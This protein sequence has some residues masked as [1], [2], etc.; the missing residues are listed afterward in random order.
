M[1]HSAQ[2]G[3]SSL[4]D[5]QHKAAKQSD[6][7][8]QDPFPD[9]AT[10]VR[11]LWDMRERLRAEARTAT[12]GTDG[13]AL[14]SVWTGWKRV[15]ELQKLQRELRRQG[16]LKKIHM[17]EQAV[18]SDN[19]Y[20]AARRFAPKTQ[21]KRLQLRTPAGH[22]QTIEEEFHD[23]KEYFSQLYGG[24]EPLMQDHLH[25]PAFIEVE[26]VKQALGQPLLARR[27]PHLLPQRL[28]GRP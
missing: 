2:A 5:S 6:A 8:P 22:L 25:Q 4:Q 20:R 9:T 19:I 12:S 21:R 10:M 1:V 24:P 17:V 3:S 11:R 28:C 13:P 15:M 18:N 7:Q 23:I 27:S 14:Q 16:R 26:E